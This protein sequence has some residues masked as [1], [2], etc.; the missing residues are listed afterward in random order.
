MTAPPPS[1]EVVALLAAAP[2]GGADGVAWFGAEPALRAAIAAAW[3]GAVVHAAAAAEAWDLLLADAGAE[4]DVI[5]WRGIHGRGRDLRV[6]IA[7]AEAGFGGVPIY[8]RPT[9]IP[10][11]FWALDPGDGAVD[12]DA[13]TPSLDDLALGRADAATL[14]GAATDGH[15]LARRAEVA[16]QIAAGLVHPE[17]RRRVLIGSAPSPPTGAPVEAAPLRRVTDHDAAIWSRTAALAP[18]AVDRVHWPLVFEVPHLVV[19]LVRAARRDA[20]GILWWAL[21]RR[22]AELPLRAPALDWARRAHRQ[23]VERANLA[24]RASVRDRS[25]GQPSVHETASLLERRY[26]EALRGLLERVDARAIEALLVAWARDLPGGFASVKRALVADALEDDDAVLVIDPES[27]ANGRASSRAEVSRLHGRAHARR[28]ELAQAEAA[29]RE[30][31]AVEVAAGEAR[32][33]GAWASL[34]QRHLSGQPAPAGAAV[35]RAT[36]ADVLRRAGRLD[37]AEEVLAPADAARLEV[38]TA[39]ARLAEARRD[40]DAAERHYRAAIAACRVPRD[41]VTAHLELASWLA[42]SGARDEAA[43]EAAVAWRLAVDTLHAV[44]RL[45]IGLVAWE[46]VGEDER[47][48]IEADVAIA[49]DDAPPTLR[50]ARAWAARL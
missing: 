39:A 11:G 49:L 40:S 25:G 3:P 48:A 9:L 24:G 32:D 37:D 1:A 44:R 17:K 10:P 15:V 4:A 7:M 47:R 30:A 12:P 34:T 20:T 33:L 14:A 13:P 46:L 38:L 50:A 8:L 35:T 22:V 28:G 16:A 43:D 2:G 41:A 18:D 26:E 6:R 21:A 42:R 29:L 19:G 45:A 31:L 23:A 36:L 27:A 5:I